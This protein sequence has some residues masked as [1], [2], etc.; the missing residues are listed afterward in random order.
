MGRR[1]VISLPLWRKLLCEQLLLLFESPSGFSF[2]S[3]THSLV[4]KAD[5]MYPPNQETFSALVSTGGVKSGPCEGDG[6]KSNKTKKRPHFEIHT[7]VDEAEKYRVVVRG[8]FMSLVSS[9]A[10]SLT[11][12]TSFCKTTSWEQKAPRE[13][14]KTSHTV[15]HLILTRDAEAQRGECTCLRSYRK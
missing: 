10:P 12:T 14:F 6:R 2:P 11:C 1:I 7:A 8:T 13:N 4:F 5:K 15:H 3:F 9:L